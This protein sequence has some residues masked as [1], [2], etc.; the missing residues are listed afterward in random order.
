MQSILIKMVQAW[1]NARKTNNADLE[2]RIRNSLFKFASSMLSKDASIE[3]FTN[4]KLMEL[5]V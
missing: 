3:F 5:D 1:L 4:L 2:K